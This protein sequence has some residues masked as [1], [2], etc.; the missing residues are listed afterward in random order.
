[1]ITEFIARFYLIIKVTLK[2]VVICSG[3]LHMFTLK[4][5]PKVIEYERVSN[6][7]LNVPISCTTPNFR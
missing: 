3:I 5:Q 6:P 4:G 1:M 7:T 2:E